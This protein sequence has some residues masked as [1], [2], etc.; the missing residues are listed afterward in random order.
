MPHFLLLL[1]ECD[2]DES[3]P[4]QLVNPLVTKFLH[5]LA[6]IDT[7]APGFALLPGSITL[8]DGG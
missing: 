6:V 8:D 5:S 1:R 3:I 4:T 7:M 2:R